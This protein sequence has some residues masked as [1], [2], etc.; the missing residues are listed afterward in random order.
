MTERMQDLQAFV[1]RAI[2]A[3]IQQAIGR[4]RA[5]RRS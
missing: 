1:D 3:D 2:A 4:L 5:H